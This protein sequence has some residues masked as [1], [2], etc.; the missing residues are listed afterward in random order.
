MLYYSGSIGNMGEV[1]HGNTVT[2][3]MEQ[4]RQRGITISSAAV[5]F[6]WKN[7]R[8]NLI[9]TPG[10]IDFTMGVEQ[11]LEVLDGA[12]VVL[13]GS[14]GVEAQTCTVW[15]QADRYNIPRLVYVNKMDR[16]DGNFDTSINS[17]ESKLDSVA[18][19]T[20]LPMRDSEGLCGI[21]DLLTL[22][23]ITFDRKSQGKN[24]VRDKL[25][26]TADG[27]LW[28]LAN[29]R[30][31]SLAD[32]LSAMDDELANVIIEEESLD[33]IS[34]QLL[35]ES[36]RRCTIGRKAVPVLLGSS[37]KNIGV[38]PLMDGVILYLPSPDLNPRR[39]DYRCFEN[40]FSARA[41][42]IVHDKQ[43]GPITFFRVYTGR[44][45]KGQRMYNV[46]RARSEQGGRLYA[47][48]ADDYEE[49]AE[50]TEGN[51]GALTGLKYTVTG[52]LLTSSASVA[53]RAE[54]FI[55]KKGKL[56][57]GAS[58][59]DPVFF[60]SIEPPSLAKQTALDTALVELTREDP[61]LRVTQNEETGQTVLSGMGELHIDII[62][63]R[64]R[65]EYKIDVDL[66]PLQIAYK[67]TVRTGHRDRLVSAHK[68]GS[69]NHSVD[70]TLSI[71]PNHQD[72]EILQLDRSHDSAANIASIHPR[73]MSAVK[74]GVRSALS[75]G[76]KLSCPV[77]DVGVK[78]HW[79][80]VGRGTSDTMIAAT[81]TRCVRKVSSRN[82]SVPR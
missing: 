81:V 69:T 20:Q 10:H 5:T 3:Y 41:F 37:Y 49:V 78:L 70:V 4:E 82:I 9:D 76:P 59:P 52:D 19:A 32:K 53:G 42:K 51:I 58:L 39:K 25:T 21:V 8:I 62:K 12:V 72:K 73:V 63:E 66:G 11:T 71:L 22:E 47:A 65:T 77:V 30:R 38:Q 33:K 61:S 24:F 56:A 16:P 44:L 55:N 29:E 79:L 57:S 80:E 18:L 48:Y 7:H 15:R 68:I 46:E 45:T 34:G 35:V 50:V 6:P 14:A 13:D 74:Q 75:H 64:I 26:E 43:R 31:R 2:D 1:H 40:N 36:V 17:I 54:K 27:S 23:K 67:E 28:E 60:C